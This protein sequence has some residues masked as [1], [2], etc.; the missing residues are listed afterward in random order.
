[1]LMNLGD[2]PEV[3]DDALNKILQNPVRAGRNLLRFIQ[4]GAEFVV[5][6]IKKI[7]IDRSQGFDIKKYLGDGWKIDE[8][9]ERSLAITEL[10]LTKIEFVTTLQDGETSIP[11]NEKLERLKKDGRVSLDAKMF[12]TFWEYKEKIPPSWKEPINNYTRFVIFDGTVLRGPDGG[13]YVLFLCWRGTRWEFGCRWLGD[14][15][16]TN[17]PSAVLRK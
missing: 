8:E 13:R 1:M 17:F 5:G 3:S 10:D 2:N 15:S 9:D 11:V 16:F 6:E 4:N 7:L 14:P 12:Q